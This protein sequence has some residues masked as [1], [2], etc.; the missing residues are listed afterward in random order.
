MA[1]C[2]LNADDFGLSSTINGS[3]IDL[4]EKRLI[5]SSTIMAGR[6]PE[7]LKEALD[8]AQ[9]LRHRAG[10]GLHLDLDSYFLFD[11]SGHYGNDELDVSGAPAQIAARRN[12][13]IIGDIDKQ[14]NV[15]TSAGI[16]ISHIDGHH[17]VHQFVDIMEILLPL[18]SDYG[19]MAMRFNEAFYKNRQNLGRAL[20]LINKFGIQ[21]TE[22]FFDFPDIERLKPCRPDEDNTFVEVMLHTE[23]PGSHSSHWRV[24][25]YEYIMSHAAGFAALQKASF[26]DLYQ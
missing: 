6:N 22:A 18:M 9:R 10:F 1:R 20:D 2:I 11:Q 3:V 5:T 19:I 4:I 24:K 16:R 13:E 17:F 25:Q 7:G 12:K 8:A 14:I 15:L 21:T 26:H 23:M